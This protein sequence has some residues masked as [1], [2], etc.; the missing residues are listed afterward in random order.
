MRSRKCNKA[1][2][3]AP[4]YYY[5]YKIRGCIYYDQNEYGKAIEDFTKAINSLDDALEDKAVVYKL[6]GKCYRVIGEEDRANSD[7]T[8][9][10]ELRNARAERQQLYQRLL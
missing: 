7:F 10:E 2:A 1:I 9:A 4:I 6:R 5:P 8:K 3:L